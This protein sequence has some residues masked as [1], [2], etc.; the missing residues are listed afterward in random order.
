MDDQKGRV[1]AKDINIPIKGYA[2]TCENMRMYESIK[3]L[4]RSIYNCLNKLIDYLSGIFKN[5]GE[6]TYMA[7]S[8]HW[9]KTNRIFYKIAERPCPCPSTKKHS[10]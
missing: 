5:T 7:A 1:C 10:A 4:Y 2:K 9:M 8:V 6:H 3:R